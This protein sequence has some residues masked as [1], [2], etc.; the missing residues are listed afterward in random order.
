M[1]IQQAVN[2]AHAPVAASAGK[3]F[4]A[5][6]KIIACASF[7]DAVR[8]AW[9]HRSSPN[10]TQRTLAEICDLYP[11]HVSNYLHAE[12]R[13]R[14]GKARLD[15]PADRIVAFELAVGNHAVS[16][17][18]NNLLALTIMEEVIFLRAA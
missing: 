3:R 14:K 1:H 18:L 7:R 16:Q 17:Y 13:D 8:L 6:S 15:L 12:A 4:L 10:M 11:P 2:H 9:E 5:L